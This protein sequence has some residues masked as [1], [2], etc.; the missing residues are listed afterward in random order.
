M[1]INIIFLIVINQPVDECPLGVHQ[2]KLVVQPGPSLRYCC[3]VAGQEMVTIVKDKMV[4]IVK[5]NTNIRPD[6][7]EH[8][9]SSLNLGQVATRNHSWRLVVDPDLYHHEDDVA[10]GDNVPHDHENPR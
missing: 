3:R 6:S 2:V 8:A 7:P 10:N 1:N 9:D 5:D 4:T